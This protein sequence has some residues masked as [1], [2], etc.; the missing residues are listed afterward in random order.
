VPQADPG[1]DE[2]P[3]LDIETVSITVAAALC[4][5]IQAIEGVSARNIQG[6]HWADLPEESGGE[7]LF[8]AE[9]PVAP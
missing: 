5:E 1:A 9:K 4:F 7:A 2:R 3:I 8:V 6:D